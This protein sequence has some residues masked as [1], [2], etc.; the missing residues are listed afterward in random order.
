MFERESRLCAFAKGYCRLLVEDIPDDKITTIP[1]PGMNHPAWILGHLAVVSDLGL[2]LLGQAAMCPKDWSRL[3]GTGSVPTT[4]LADYPTREDLLQAV[5]KGYTALAEAAQSA[6]PARIDAPHPVA[7]FRDSLPTIGD[8][9]GH[10]LT[11]HLASH[12]GQLSAWRRTQGL[13]GV[14]KL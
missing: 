1:Y 14:L 5:D 6:D 4:H 8:L 10:L 2:R 11:V 13:P 9:L 3:F 12:L 7:F